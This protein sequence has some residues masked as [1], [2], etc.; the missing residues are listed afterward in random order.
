M[1]TDATCLERNLNLVLQV[2]EITPRVVVCVNLMD[3]AQRKGIS[4]DLKALEEELGVPAVGTAAKN[5]TGL[6]ELPGYCG[7]R[8]YRPHRYPAPH[9]LLPPRS[10]SRRPPHNL[11]LTIDNYRRENRNKCGNN[12][13][14]PI[15]KRDYPFAWIQDREGVITSP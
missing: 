14:S 10:G 11:Q 3:E 6:E 5:G 1:V 13:R 12:L 2:L 4:I 7:G 15:K 8:G 9:R